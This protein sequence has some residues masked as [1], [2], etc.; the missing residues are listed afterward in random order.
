MVSG[1]WTGKAPGRPSG[2]DLT[3][4]Q[5]LAT[6]CWPGAGLGLRLPKGDPNSMPKASYWF[7]K[8]SGLPPWIV[9]SRFCLLVSMVV[10]PHNPAGGLLLPARIRLGGSAALTIQL[11][12]VRPEGDRA[13]AHRNTGIPGLGVCARPKQQQGSG[14]LSAPLLLLD[15]QA[16]SSAALPV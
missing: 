5:A 4:P 9:S 16:D 3:T 6:L 2:Q 1:V 8:R 12:P 14:R 13:R 7:T 15:S 11:Y 10:P